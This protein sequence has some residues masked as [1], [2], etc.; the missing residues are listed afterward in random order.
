MLDA[1]PREKNLEKRILNHLR[2]NGLFTRKIHV[3]V[4]DPDIICVIPLAGGQA[5]PVAF[6]LKR[7]EKFRPAEV[8][9]ERLRRLRKQG[10]QA[11]VV[12]SWDQYLSIMRVFQIRNPSLKVA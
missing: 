5:I 4:G 6:E 10:F 2:S 11:Y 7:H 1:T 9:E 8:Q 3:V 12:Y